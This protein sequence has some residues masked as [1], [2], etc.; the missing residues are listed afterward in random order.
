MISIITGSL[1]PLCLLTSSKLKPSIRKDKQIIHLVH[2]Y[3][4]KCNQ[5][6]GTSE[7]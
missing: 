7:F 3:H 2:M 4:E 5:T 1:S 6:Q